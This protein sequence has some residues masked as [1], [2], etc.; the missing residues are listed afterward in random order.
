MWWWLFPT[1]DTLGEGRPLQRGQTQVPDLHRARG[2]RDEDVV[3]FQV[4]VNDGRRSGVQEV[5]AFEDLPAPRAQ[6]LDFHHLE[7][8]QVAAGN[9]GRKVD[10]NTRRRLFDSDVN[11]SSG[12]GLPKEVFL[13]YYTVILLWQDTE[14][15]PRGS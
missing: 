6:H 11:S 1:Y 7:A 3:A 10:I 8:L 12:I 4:P 14:N 13:M 9:R 5:K 15:H 2:P